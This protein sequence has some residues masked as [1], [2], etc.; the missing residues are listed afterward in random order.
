M[1]EFFKNLLGGNKSDR[2]IRSFEPQVNQINELYAGLE[3]RPE[4]YLQERLAEIREEIDAAREAARSA[5]K[6]RDDIDE[7]IYQAEQNALDDHL[8]E[9]FAI[10]KDGCR[11]LLGQEFKLLGQA[12]VWD[13]VP[14]DVQLLGA[15]TLHQGR[16]A[17]MKTGEGKTLV[18]TMPIILNALTGR[19]VHLVTVNDFL[20]QRD[21]HWM[22]QVYDYLGLSIG[23]IV[24]DMT[25]EE[26]KVAYSKN[27]TSGTNNEFG[28][29]YLRDNMAV[30]P[31]NQVQR[32]HVYVIVDEVDSVLV[33]EARTPLIISG[34][35]DAPKDTMYTDLKSKVEQL[36]RS[37]TTTAEL[38]LKTES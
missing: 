27:I 22:G 17:E 24:N 25:P 11:R 36:I 15:I 38:I 33:D 4:G 30:S 3:D 29:D 21:S 37:Q 8:V 32:G 2:D 9:V 12:V 20:A 13:M 26:R 34:Q 5:N 1:T 35:V 7:H 19:G 28:F 31:E 14:F 10:V 6:D 23:C 16:I 18:A